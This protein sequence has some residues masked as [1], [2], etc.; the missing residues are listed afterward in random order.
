M[1]EDLNEGP[2]LL[3]SASAQSSAD[4]LDYLVTLSPPTVERLKKLVVQRNAVDQQLQAT[5]LI[6]LE[7]MG[8][9]G[10]IMLPI[11]LEKG[12]VRLRPLPAPTPLPNRE[13]RRKAKPKRK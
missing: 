4:E 2:S 13:Q 7:A 11:D 8:V 6:A 3:E 5:L 1:V 12:I 9:Q 10:E